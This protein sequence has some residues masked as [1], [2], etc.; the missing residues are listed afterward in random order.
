MYSYTRGIS[1]A[2]RIGQTATRAASVLRFV[3]KAYGMFE[4]GSDALTIARGFISTD[5]Q[6]K[7]DA[8]MA[9]WN[10][11]TGVRNLWDELAGV[12]TFFRGDESGMTEF[13]SWEARNQM[14][15]NNATQE[16]ALRLSQL[17]IDTNDF[18]TLLANHALSSR[19]YS[20]PLI[21]I[22]TYPD[23]ASVFSDGSVYQIRIPKN[24]V[25]RN[26]RS[27]IAEEYE[28]VVKNQIPKEWIIAV[29]QQ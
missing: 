27:F 26:H 1:A 29:H 12:R 22:T 2:Y 6:A 5:P 10:P 28:W 13:L 4:F 23:S 9:M 18:D 21:S 14:Q 7:Y 24:Q 15:L 19:T 11:A 17:K 8:A 16:D 25:V 3:G 20:S